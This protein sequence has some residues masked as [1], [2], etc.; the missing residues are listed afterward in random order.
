MFKRG[1]RKMGVHFL[2]TDEQYLKIG[3]YAMLYR[4]LYLEAE[5]SCVRTVAGITSVVVYPRHIA[6]YSGV[7]GRHC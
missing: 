7:E 4:S 3:F 6:V 1:Y 5:C 2:L